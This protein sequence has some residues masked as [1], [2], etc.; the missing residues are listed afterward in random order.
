L[1][2]P[3]YTELAFDFV[4][5]NKAEAASALRVH[6]SRIQRRFLERHHIEVVLKTS[7]ER[8]PGF[9]PERLEDHRRRAEAREGRLQHVQ[10]GEGCEQKPVGR[11]EIAQRQADKDNSSGKGEDSAVEVHGSA[12][13]GI[14][15]GSGKVEEVADP[16]FEGRAGLGAGLV[17]DLT[18]AV[19]ADQGWYAP[20]L[21]AGGGK[22]EIMGSGDSS[23][24]SDGAVAISI[25]GSGD[26]VVKGRATCKANVMGSGEAHCAP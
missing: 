14:V 23:F 11:D 24:A 13:I 17:C 15:W 3:G 18:A 2:E 21:K 10:A 19:P 16:G 1:I 25:L 6:V 26:A 8:I 20:D 5:R 22:V 4:L 7:P 9:E 12:P